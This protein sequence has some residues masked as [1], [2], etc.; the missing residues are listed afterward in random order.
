MARVNKPKLYPAPR[1]CGGK[2]CYPSKHQ[3]EVVKMEQELRN[4][5]ELSIYRC[6]DCGNWHLTR[7]K[8]DEHKDID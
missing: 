5:V 8:N 4:H 2:M 3:A 7:S 6:I 1:K